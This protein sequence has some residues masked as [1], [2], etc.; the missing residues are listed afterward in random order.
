MKVP[1]QTTLIADPAHSLPASASLTAPSLST[2]G[3]VSA[4]ALLLQQQLAFKRHSPRKVVRKVYTGGSTLPKILNRKRPGLPTVSNQPSEQHEVPASGAGQ[5][6]PSV[7]SE[8][9]EAEAQSTA[10]S[11][12]ETDQHAEATSNQ[13]NEEVP[14][15]SSS[16]LH[17]IISAP[18]F[19]STGLIVSTAS[20]ESKLPA[21]ALSASQL[22]RLKQKPDTSTNHSA[23]STIP[24]H[25]S[26]VNTL[27]FI[28]S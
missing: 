17:Q 23:S 5:A 6:S 13:E 11:L 20:E 28:N 9:T 2:E 10:G 18:R 8:A 3:A 24:S 27:K 25:Y 15:T 19:S 12:A 7:H 22:L 21:R 4:S 16:T 1:V 26:Q 14:E